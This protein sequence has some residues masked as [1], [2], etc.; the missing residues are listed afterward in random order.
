MR[1]SAP[2]VH[3]SAY[4]EAPP[5]IGE[6]QRSLLLA[7]WLFSPQTD[8]VVRGLFPAEVVCHILSYLRVE[9]HLCS[10]CH[11]RVW[12]QVMEPRRAKHTCRDYVWFG[13]S[14]MVIGQA[15]RPAAAGD[16]L[17][18]MMGHHVL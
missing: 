1:G 10:R 18:I 7:Q 15:M 12:C 13:H 17:R 4:A 6:W 3:Y 8:S 16:T 14:N 9:H 5:L 11:V 2:D